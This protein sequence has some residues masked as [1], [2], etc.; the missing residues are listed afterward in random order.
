MG[1]VGEVHVSECV[2]VCDR[3]GGATLIYLANYRG[4]IRLSKDDVT[5]ACHTEKSGKKA[6]RN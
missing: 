3:D 5:G 1:M 4:F 6:R 2:A